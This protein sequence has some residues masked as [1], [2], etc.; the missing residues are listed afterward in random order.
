MTTPVSRGATPALP[1]RHPRLTVLSG[2]SGVG[3]STV[4]AHLRKAHPE[5]WLSV[6]ATTRRPRPGERHGVHYFFVDDEEFDKLVANGELLEWAEFAGNR[7]G[8]PRRAVL[9]KLE[10]GEPVLLEIDLQG[11]RLVRASMPE[12]QLV[13]L[14]PPGWDELVRRLTGRGTEAPEVIERRLA[15]ARTELAAESEFDTTLVN[16]SVEDVAAELLALL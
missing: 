6:S 2:P 8:T 16:T 13:F 15:A 1:D 12:A 10:A 7:Y 11:A 14:A 4:V 9:E 5:V 3:K